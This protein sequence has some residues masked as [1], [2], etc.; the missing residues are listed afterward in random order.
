M[1]RLA[2]HETQRRY[3]CMMESAEALG[4][5]ALRMI[6][7]DI[8]MTL[9]PDGT[10]VTSADEALNREFIERIGADFPDDLVWGEEES[11]SRKGDLDLADRR[12]LWT[13]DPIDGTTGFWRCYTQKRFRE[14]KATTL[15]SGF[16]PGETTPTISV[17]HNPF[18]DQQTTL[19][20]N[21][22]GVYYQ[23]SFAPVSRQIEMDRGGPKTLQ[24]VR[25]FE[26][27]SWPGARPDLGEVPQMIP[28]ARRVNH[29]LF[30]AAVALG[31]IDLGVFPGPS[32]PHDVAPG[33]HIVNRAGGTV[34]SLKGEEYD[35][36][37]WRIYP[38][39]G[40]LCAA[41]PELADGFLERL[42]A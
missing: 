7:G 32:H 33:T 6:Q 36:I 27:N 23:T 37:D 10:K 14:C 11:N 19:S 3:E 16:A 41:T 12:W 4:G 17:V 38:I 9:K 21:P 2:R 30:M 31:D 22:D 28:Y 1:N 15:I 29:Q 26:Q 35:Q 42:A 5:L 34:R 39:N 24:Q 20:A 18:Q 40:V 13:I 25:R 8:T